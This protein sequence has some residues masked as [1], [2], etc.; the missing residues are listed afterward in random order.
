MNKHDITDEKAK[1][2]LLSNIT[3]LEIRRALLGLYDI[4]RKMGLSPADACEYVLLSV[5]KRESD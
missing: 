4:K 3:H 1:D 2:I 5:L